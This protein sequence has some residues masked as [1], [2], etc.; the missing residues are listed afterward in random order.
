MAQLKLSGLYLIPITDLL[1]A[2][3]LVWVW[4]MDRRYKRIPNTAVF[5]IAAVSLIR[6]HDNPAHAALG[7]IL[8]L[9]M[10]WPFWQRGTMGAGDVKIVSALGAYTGGLGGLSVFVCS[11]A[12]W[13]IP[14][15]VYRL[16]KGTL[17]IF[18]LDTARALASLF[19]GRLDMNPAHYETVRHGCWMLP[20][21]ILWEVLHYA[22]YL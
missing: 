8:P 19:R 22:G 21:F 7:L 6:H 10:F 14:A 4:W 2:L 9:V 5:I 3:L 1:V 17:L 16:H 15:L 20:G 11:C 13:I 12:L 18:I